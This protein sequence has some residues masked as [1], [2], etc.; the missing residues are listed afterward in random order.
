[1]TGLEGISLRVLGLLGWD[2]G[3]GK[4]FV[5]EGLKDVADVNI[6]AY[7]PV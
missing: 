2:T 6:H 7:C 4:E 5:G 1:V 3:K